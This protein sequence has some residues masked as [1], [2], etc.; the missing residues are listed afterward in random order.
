[1]SLV[2]STSGWPATWQHTPGGLKFAVRH[3][4]MYADNPTETSDPYLHSGSTSL[5]DQL[6]SVA[7]LLSRY[8]VQFVFR[9]HAH[10]YERNAQQPGE[11]FVSYVTGG[12]GAPLEPVG[13]G[14]GCHS[15]DAY[16]VGWS[17]TKNKGY[18][19]GGGDAAHVGQP[20]V[21]FLL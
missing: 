21:H 7:S 16:A 18:A 17:P 15:F 2:M 1:M 6:G 3:F 8:G 5:T 11:C 20:G 14:T 19:C 12:G 4:L 10:I 9:G 13:T